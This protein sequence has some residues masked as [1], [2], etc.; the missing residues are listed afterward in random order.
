MT[1]DPASGELPVTLYWQASH[2]M[3]DDYE[4]ILQLVDDDRRVWGNGSA[5]PNDWAYPTTFWRPDLETIAA[6]QKIIFQA[7]TL[8][9]GRYWLAV[10]LF[11][12]ATGRRL[13]LIGGKG[14]SPDTFFSDPLKVPL[15]PPPPLPS[16]AAGNITFGEVARLAG[17]VN[18]DRPI[19]TGQPVRFALLWE[20]LTRPKA[21]YTVFVHLLDA[22]G[23]I[24]AG[25]DT[26]PRNTTYPTTIWSPGER[27]L[28]EHILP[29]PA[30][31]PPGQY[32]LAIGLYYQPTGERLP[33]YFPD[34]RKDTEGRL[35]L[36]SPITIIAP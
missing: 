8:K 32:R 23:A 13:P 9:S 3:V 24:V 4:V 31:L 10:A 7:G 25:H 22:N 21:D 19:A 34:G 6:Q 36:T 14:D 26:Q 29:T 17:L 20:A 28:D 2:Q 11:N 12:P 30:S 16:L 15:H 1:I 5:R 35:I 27:I 18:P 33:L